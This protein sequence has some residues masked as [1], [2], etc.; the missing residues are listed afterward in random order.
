MIA[1]KRKLFFSFLC[2]WVWRHGAHDLCGQ[3]CG[4]GHDLRG[5]G[6][7]PGASQPGVQSAAGQASHAW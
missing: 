3:V 6:P 2:S 1:E 7:H 5:G 4:A